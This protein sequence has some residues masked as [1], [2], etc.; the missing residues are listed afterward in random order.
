MKHFAWAL[1]LL[2][3]CFRLDGFLYASRHED[4]YVFDADSEDPLEVVTADRY[5]ELRV[6]VNDEVTLGGV[7][8]RAAEQPPLGHIWYFLGQGGTVERT[9]GKLKRISNLGF[10]VFCV[11]YRGSGVSSKVSPT[12][13]GIGEDTAAALAYLRA[14]IGAD[15][16][17]GY[18]GHSLGTAT[19]TQRA[20]KNPPAA[21]LLESALAS[22]SQLKSDASQLDFPI[23][24]I[25]NATW[26]TEHRIERV[27]VPLLMLHGI[28]DDY[29]RIENSERVF[30]HANEPK[31][32]V[33]I[34]GAHHGDIPQVAPE[35]WADEVRAHF[36]NAFQR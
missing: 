3:S 10:D 23:G 25:A 5:E 17:L 30:A 31:R 12:E 22:L 21:L 7:Y 32:L 19:A 8:L 16:P 4:A 13:D 2:S 28:D 33:R 34:P 14:R 27:H 15:T 26:D 36:V 9:F 35:L 1:L 29:V 11:D 20:E 24:F 6:V 18:Y